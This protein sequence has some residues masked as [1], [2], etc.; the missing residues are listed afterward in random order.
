MKK[1]EIEHPAYQPPPVEEEAAAEG[2]AEESW[3][4]MCACGKAGR[5]YDDGRAMT[6]CEQCLV[7]SHLGC[8]LRAEAR[9][10]GREIGED[11]WEQ[12]SYVDEPIRRFGSSSI[13]RISPE[14]HR[15]QFTKAKKH[16]PQRDMSI[17]LTAKESQICDLLDKVVDHI[18]DSHPEQPKLVLRIAGGWVRD[19]LLGMESHDIDI[20]IDHMSG[21]DL[22]QH[23]NQYLKDNNYP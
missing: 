10:L 11:E 23:V 3:M 8:S 4:F 13:R 6:A 18:H 21:F 19:K 7:W 9:R 16:R 17:V 1:I 14:P 20:A 12:L 2:D 5:N 15:K 22:A